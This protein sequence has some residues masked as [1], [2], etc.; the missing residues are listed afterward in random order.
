MPAAGSS[1]EQWRQ[2][3]R[4]YRLTRV[5]YARDAG[6]ALSGTGG[7]HAGG[8]WH[9]KGQKVIYA[10]SSRALCTLERIVH[11]ETGTTA[12][13]DDM[14][15][16]DIVIPSLVSREVISADELD[17]I[18]ANHGM[19][20][21]PPD[22][23]HPAHPACAR[24]GAEWLASQS[25]CLLVVPSAVVPY[26]ANILLNPLHSDMSMVLEATAQVFEKLPFTWDRRLANVV[27]LAAAA[28]ARTAG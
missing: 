19:A 12:A 17:E 9:I 15:F 28:R 2:I 25:S 24:I 16:F 7:L 4:A 6:D 13:G 10:G 5:A 26:E 1:K 21:E 8:R 14:V 22:W 23:R 27:D 20:G 18:V 11:L 3:S